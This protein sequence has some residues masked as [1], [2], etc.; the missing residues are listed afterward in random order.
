[1]ELQIIGRKNC[2]ETRRAE[3][4]FKERDIDFQFRDLREKEIS[5]GELKK[6]CAKIQAEDLI[7]K[8]SKAFKSG[9]YDYL[10]YDAFEELLEHQALLKTPI[11]RYMQNVSVGRDE[12]A[13][14]EIA[15]NLQSKG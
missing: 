5:P 9:G 14:K 7:D 4:F 1:M 11:L 12:E 15:R 6:V 2:K 10:V 3:R 8:E 13:W